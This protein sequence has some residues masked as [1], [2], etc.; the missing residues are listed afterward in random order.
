M[1][2]R[3]RTPVGQ[4][5]ADQVALAVGRKER[6]VPAMEP[7]LGQTSDNVAQRVRPAAVKPRMLSTPKTKKA[8]QFGHIGN[9]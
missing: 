9:S 8:S 1:Q 4:V 7:I 3:T 5:V 2:N 6:R